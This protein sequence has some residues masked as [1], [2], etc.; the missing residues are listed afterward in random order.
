MTYYGQYKQDQI[1]NE[2]IFKNFEHGFFVD[3]GAHDG[4]SLNNTLFFEHQLGWTGINIEPIPFIFDQCQINRKKCTNIC[5]AIDKDHGE[6]FFRLN[7]GYTEMLSG[8][9]DYL[10]EKHIR[11]TESENVQHGCTSEIVK[12]TTKPLKAIFQEQNIT[13][14]HFLSIDVEGAEQAVIE[15]VDFDKVFID[16]IM[17]ENNYPESSAPIVQHLEKHNYVRFMCNIDD[18]VMVHKDS[19]FIVK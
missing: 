19:M 7:H 13:R 3:V 16:V 5:C 6:K 14:V 12:V 15:S 8:L 4:V 2:L 18:I 17:F 11:R 1:L 10:C 9:V